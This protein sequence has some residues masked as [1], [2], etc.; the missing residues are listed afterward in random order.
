M[1]GEIVVKNPDDPVLAKL[2]DVAQRLGA[3]VI[4]DDGE[5]YP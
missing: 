2:I 3:H 4:G 1:D 5:T